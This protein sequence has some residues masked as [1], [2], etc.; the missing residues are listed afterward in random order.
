M[1]EAVGLSLPPVDAETPATE[2]RFP[3]YVVG[4]GASAGGLDALERF[5]KQCPVATGAVFVVV[6]HLSP[7][8][9]SMMRNLL[10]RHTA[11]PVVI[12]VDGMLV[13]PDTVYLIPPGSLMYIAGS[14]LHLEPKNPHG[15]TLPIDIFFRSLAKDYGRRAVGII[16]SGT[17][18][19]GSR[20]AAAIHAAGG[21]V[22][23]QDPETAKFDGMPRS[24]L[25]T[26]V[27]DAVLPVESLSTRLLA[28][29]QQITLPPA[30]TPQVTILAHDLMSREELMAAILEQL[31]QISGIDFTDYKLAN[32]SRRIGRRMQVRHTPDLAAY[33][34][35]LEQERE[36][37]LALRRECLIAVTSFF[38]DP[39][40]FA[41]LYSKVILP[42]VTQTPVTTPLRVW[43]A[44]VASGEEAYTLAMLFSE[45]FASQ[46]RWANLKIFATDVDANCIEKAGRGYYASSAV[47]ELTPE[48]LRRFF[49]SSG[50]GFVVK[51]ELRQCVVFARHNL[52]T[53]PPFTR[54]D[55]VVCRN[56]L[57]YFKPDA[58]RRALLT[59]QYAVRDGGCLMLGSSE[60]VSV[61]SEGLQV[62]DARQKLFR[63][64]GSRLPPLEQ[65]GLRTYPVALPG[66]R[67]TPPPT[68]QPAGDSLAERGMAALLARFAPPALIVNA[69]HE[70]LHLFGEVS[71]YLRPR[72][73]VASLELRR[74]LPEP[75]IPVALALLYKGV[76]EREPG[77]LTSHPVEIAPQGQ[78]CRIALR[79]Q[80]VPPPV[81]A[82]AQALV[83]PEDQLFLLSFHETA[84]RARPAA[85][86]V[87][88]D[89]ETLAHVATLEQELAATR[90][91]LQNSVEALETSN[92]E[93]Q[94]TNEELMASNEELQSSNEELQ[95]VNEEMSTVNAEFQ[96]KMEILNRINADLDQM[97]KV[98]A[99]AT[100]FVDAEL[101]ITRFSPDAVRLF[102]LRDSDLGRC[103]DD[104]QH[105]LD[106][107]ELM[108]D[109]AA[110]LRLNRMLEREVTTRD[111]QQVYLAR[112]LPYSVSASTRRGVVASF[113][114]VSCLHH[115]QRLQAIMDALPEHIAV[116]DAAGTIVQI[117]A[118]WQRFAKANGDPD[119][120]CSGVGVNYLQVCQVG[121]ASPSQGLPSEAEQAAQAVHGIHAVLAGHLPC[122]T[123]T[124][125]CHSPTQQRWFVMHVAPVQGDALGAVI[126]HIDVSAWYAEQTE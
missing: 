32:L 17:G 118:A 94:A 119:L 82:Q 10:A 58:Q 50:D 78:I 95:S 79:L 67:A 69:K 24:A 42:L 46:Q 33:L 63:R 77:E 91:S 117:N 80:P 60:T 21:C 34:S 26:G 41:A 48:R 20:G 47:M 120:R 81:D 98:T 30:P 111:Q 2:S 11:M 107:P 43:V 1:N 110:T 125:P 68:P 29:L 56:T 55:L 84:T 89:A 39:E 96:E 103:L 74:L 6:Q 112:L 38:R 14:H 16:L 90:A 35:V 25:A 40:A 123:L 87:D 115:A 93:L 7:D 102:K 62:L 37:R 22:L 122:F 100:V 31:Q 15:L 8:H 109:L 53:D 44:G 4:L 121:P 114:D 66:V 3:G 106:Y 52:L 51:D 116:V 27:V 126:S 12:V 83:D 88:I 9:K 64:Y 71:A 5:F 54:M 13:A 76:R 57:I 97:A 113:V 49:S 45:A 72:S 73:G 85:Q 92:E 18:T 124:Y 61:D 99:M 108:D 105:G 59:L 75:L 70:V 104:I 65:M 28:H 36:E 86:S 19:D 23:V 101:Q